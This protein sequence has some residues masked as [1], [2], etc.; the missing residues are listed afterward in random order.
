MGK[1]SNFNILR[2]MEMKRYLVIISVIWLLALSSLTTWAQPGSLKEIKVGMIPITDCLSLFAAKE[3]GY[4]GQQGL[5]VKMQPMAGGAVIIPAIAGGSLDIGFSAV[6]TTLLAVDKGFDFV[7]IADGAYEPTS[8]PFTGFVMVRKDSGINSPRDLAGKKVGVNLLK[9]IADLSIMEMVRMDGGDAKK[10]T[11]V[12]IPFPRM[13]QPLIN[14]QIDAGVMVEPFYTF[15]KANPSL[16]VLFRNLH[17]VKPGMIVANYVTTRSWIAKQPE[18]A[19]KFA[20]A[21]NK[22]SA[23]VNN[24]PSEARKILPRYTR[25]TPELAGKIG[26]KRFGTSVDMDGLGWVRDLLIRYGLI[27]K[28]L[29]LE[30]L[31]FRTAR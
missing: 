14:R 21:L 12:E 23:Y 1:L 2:G 20:Q 26:I 8:P 22:A 31:V 19:E 29:K 10:I 27:K 15:V 17:D 30:S 24:N 3:L 18:L 9:N 11:W 7:M 25:L 16:K 4:F 5:E 6:I 28:G 13:A